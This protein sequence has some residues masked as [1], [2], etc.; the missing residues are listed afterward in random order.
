MARREDKELIKKLKRAAYIHRYDP[1]ALIRDALNEG[2]IDVGEA[3][4]HVNS[5]EFKERC[6]DIFKW[7]KYYLSHILT[8]DF[9]DLHRYMVEVMHEPVTC[10]VAPRGHAKTTMMTTVI[11][12]YLACNYPEKYKFYLNIQGTFRKAEHRNKALK[13]EFQYNELIKRDYGDMRT[14]NWAVMTRPALGNLVSI[15]SPI[16]P[17]SW[18]PN[19]VP[20]V[21]MD[22]MSPD[23]PSEKPSNW[24]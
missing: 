4:L 22:A 21:S 9:N 3:K 19:A 15:P 11:P 7:G 12:L 17:A 2:V 24:R 6:L 8:E 5:L 23:L 1:Y 18:H 20:S 10:T 16:N 13:A 14:E